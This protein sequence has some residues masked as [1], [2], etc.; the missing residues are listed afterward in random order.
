MTNEHHRLHRKAKKLWIWI[1]PDGIGH[2][3]SLDQILHHLGCDIPRRDP[4]PDL[5]PEKQRRRT[6]GRER[7]YRRRS[8]KQG[9]ER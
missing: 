1:D 6:A 8:R 7:E 4:I 3:V 9:S 5:T 2:V